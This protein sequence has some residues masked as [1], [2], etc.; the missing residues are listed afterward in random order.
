MQKMIR[1]IICLLAVT[2]ICF[3]ACTKANID[4]REPT[5][6]QIYPEQSEYVLPTLA[7]YFY[8]TDGQTPYIVKESDANGNFEGTLPAGT[9]RV[10]GTNT[11]AKDVV[12]TGMDSYETAVVRANREGSNR[13]TS[14]S[15]GYTMLLQP[16]LVYSTV[17]G[18]L[19][20]TENQTI[21]KEPVP[22][23][24]TKQLNLVFTM[25]N[26][27]DA[28]VLSMTG[29]LPGIYPAVYLYT[30]QET[31]IER[32]PDMAVSFET[33]GDGGERKA[34][35]SLFGLCN[36]EGG[37]AYNNTL[38]LELTMTDGSVEDMAV[39]LTDV[40]SDIIQQNQGTI[41]VEVSLEVGIEKVGM[42]LNAVV[43]AWRQGGSGEGDF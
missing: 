6:I 22:V 24:L 2:G 10:I 5:K 19:V 43:A 27:L 42:K 30:C 17:I 21:R 28:E 16:A 1:N 4:Y 3:W 34:Q 15:D 26:G 23:L 29:V 14:R 18:E 41:P 31:E 32:S 20:V 13:L 8:N 25:Q 40:L 11:Q 35:I 36:P 33:V 38:A 39:D 7:Y 37:Q 9:Y 12:F